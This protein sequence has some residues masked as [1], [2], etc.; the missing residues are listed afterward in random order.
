[1]PAV[2]TFTGSTVVTSPDNGVVDGQCYVY[3]LTGTDNVGNTS[4]VVTSNAVL[5]D[6]TKPTDSVTLNSVS[7]GV[8]KSGTTIYYKGN[9]TG[10]FKLGRRQRRLL[11][12]R[13]GDLR[14]PVRR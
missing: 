9:A 2:G 7:G 11:R 14:H 10:S 6:A 12:A 5:V 4:S 13:L 1:C 3:T 8:Y